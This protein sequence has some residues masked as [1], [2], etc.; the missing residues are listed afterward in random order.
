MFTGSAGDMH[1][2]QQTNFYK[3]LHGCKLLNWLGNPLKIIKTV[4]GHRLR[5]VETVC[6]TLVAAFAVAAR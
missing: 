1:P 5:Y 3:Y 4:D 2:T 6:E